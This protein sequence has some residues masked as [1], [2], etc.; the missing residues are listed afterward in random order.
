MSVKGGQPNI[1]KPKGITMET[2][3]LRVLGVENFRRGV[4]ILLETPDGQQVEHI[5]GPQGAA[6]LSRALQHYERL[7]HLRKSGGIPSPDVEKVSS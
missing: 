3:V 5:I 7:F 1:G 6:V 4:A 2:K